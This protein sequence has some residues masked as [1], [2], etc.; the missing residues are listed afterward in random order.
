MG[1]RPPSSWAGR[2]DT[3]VPAAAPLANMTH[4][5]RGW[6][7]DSFS[8]GTASCPKQ[9]AVSSDERI[10]DGCAVPALTSDSNPASQVSSAHPPAP[11][12]R[13]STHDLVPCRCPH[14]SRA[15]GDLFQACGEVQNPTHAAPAPPRSPGER[16]TARNGTLRRGRTRPRRPTFMCA[17][18]AIRNPGVEPPASRHPENPRRHG[19]EGSPRSAS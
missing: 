13:G 12:R 11:A 1:S 15:A 18:A 19:L 10:G 5:L 7:S 17:A 2:S 8:T 16:I 9:G 4:P 14:P 6:R 3:T